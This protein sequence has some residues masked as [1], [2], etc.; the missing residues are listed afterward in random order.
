MGPNRTQEICIAK[1]TIK[2]KNWQ[3]GIKIFAN[4]ENKGL[5]SKIYKQLMEGNIKKKK[6]PKQKWTENLS[7]CF[8]KEDT[9]MT[10]KHMKRYSTSLIITE[11]Q[12]KTTVRYH[13]TTEWRSSKSVQTINVGKGLKKRKPSYT[14]G[15]NVN[16]YKHY[17]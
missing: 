8:S 9:Q 17:G 12:I 5:A 10:S 4:N 16:W 7:R 1:E 15:G 3:N 11:M 6:D 13:L 14:T 2:P